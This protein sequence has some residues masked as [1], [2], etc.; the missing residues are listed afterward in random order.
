MIYT[1]DKDEM[2]H[3]FPEVSEF[4]LSAITERIQSFP[5]FLKESGCKFLVC[6]QAENIL[7]G[8]TYYFGGVFELLPIISALMG[9]FHIVT[10]FYSDLK[11]NAAMQEM[12]I[13][14]RRVT[15]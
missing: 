12:D 5:G 15:A 11:G 14:A 13:H 8:R 4:F 2:L 7:D 1:I 9:D 6:S 3:L 10:L